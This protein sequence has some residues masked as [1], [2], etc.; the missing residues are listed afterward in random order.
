MDLNDK[1]KELL[2]SQ[3]DIL[4]EYEEV[5]E[6]INEDDSINEN[7]QLKKEFVKL[8]QELREVKEKAEKLGTENIGIKIA[9]REQMF[10]ERNSILKA[11]LK[12]I[13]LYFGEE[14][15]GA[16]N[17]LL[18]LE[19]A[20][21][22]KIRE[23][24]RIATEELLEN[25]D[26]IEGQINYLEQMLNE[27]IA[28]Q[29]EQIS[30]TYKTSLEEMKAEY[31]NEQREIT[32]EE[33]I[34][35]QKHNN[36]EVNI[37]L[38]WI[39]KLGIILL[40]FGVATAMKYTYSAW[41]TD[42]MKAISG[43][44]LGGLMLGAGEWFNKKEKSL[45]A[46]GLCGGGIGTLYLAVF[47]SYFFFGILNLPIS[48]MISVLITLGALVLSQRY[49]SRTIAGISLVGGYLP[50]FSF[51]I[52]M[53]MSGASVYVAMGYLMILN[54]LMLV[55]ALGRRW[56]FINYLSFILNIPCLIWLVFAADSEVVGISYGFLTF[57]MYLGIT[58]AYPIK[59]NIK[60]KVADL[61]LLAFNTVINCLVIYILFEVAEF[62]AYQGFLA[63]VYAVGYFVLSR[64]I[65][66]RYSQEKHVEALFSITALTFSIL[67]IPFQFGVEWA[68]M[69][70][71]IEAILILVF[72]KKRSVE[73]IELGGW[74]ILGLCTFGFVINDIIWG[75][76]I[77]YFAIRY[78]L[79]AFGLVYVFSL[80]LPEY[81]LNIGMK[82]TEKGKLIN[83][84]KYSVIFNTWIYLLR[85][86]GKAY[87]LYM[88][89]IMP[90]GYV[91][92]YKTII[93]ALITIVVAYGLLKIKAIR[94]KG[95]IVISTGL[96]IL[97]NLTCI[98]LTF[99]R[100]DGTPTPAARLIGVVVLIIYNILA[101]LSI[102]DLTLQLIKKQGMSI[103]YYPLAMVIYLL[104]ILTTFL[105]VQLDLQSINL[106]ISIV[107]VVSAMGC[108]IFGF[109]KNYLL[110]R[111]FG[112]G[113]SIF[114]T[115]KLFIF[116]LS[117]L[118]GAG[119]IIA[120]FCFGLVLIGISFIYQKLNA[121]LKEEVHSEENS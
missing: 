93:L 33:I 14:Q 40:L 17:R 64:I 97:S 52:L 95:V 69:G 21:R 60:L 43:F 35:K 51:G 73:K 16:I 96:L 44:L 34:K 59:E 63:L 113:L 121:S 1:V 68:A 56:I 87:D 79:L 77:E 9:L 11:S 18:Y 15:S 70:W 58:L 48:M 25:K 2:E 62:Q 118:A 55:I 26:E 57:I 4:K 90:P 85:M 46:L 13:E 98:V 110:I 101:F 108:I 102:K 32:E 106:I 49:N 120:Y 6:K 80:Y 5:L 91:S 75:W 71:L 89:K 74:I 24:N 115:A 31:D 114:A 81:N 83:V 116:D 47:S 100:I 94:D 23:I 104:G 88:V 29:K 92:F 41:F 103:E 45:F 42:Y 112:L 38:N 7:I 37:G 8:H 65:R 53:D 72:A 66:K 82:Y 10:N 86:A 50:F 36:M 76:D 119:R 28:V 39:N 117:N 109:K 111:R 30:E 27:K 54:L 84:F 105:T 12:K 20:S 61:I 22:A 3:K 67:M 107:F 19:N 78:S 99:Y